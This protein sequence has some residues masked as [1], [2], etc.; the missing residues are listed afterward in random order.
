MKRLLAAATLVMFLCLSVAG[1]Q[2]ATPQPP[3]AK[4]LCVFEGRCVGYDC[5]QE[6]VDYFI[7]QLTKVDGTFAL[8]VRSDR[9]LPLA[10]ANASLDLRRFPYL[11]SGTY[12][13][14]NPVVFLRRKSGMLAV[15]LPEAPSFPR[16]FFF[17]EP[18]DSGEPTELWFIP[19]GAALPPHTDTISPWYRFQFEEIDESQPVSKRL[20]VLADRLRERPAA[21]GVIRRYFGGMKKP[22]VMNLQKQTNAALARAG[23]PADRALVSPYS[24]DFVKA[25]T[26]IFIAEI[27]PE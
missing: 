22:S 26:R 20:Q 19:K 25:R 8:C 9:P 2:T 14:P 24:V 4:L 18:I 16:T 23:M 27:L 12:E 7:G 3:T 6:V 13:S 10:L 1:G 21:Y 5:N 15:S 17:T 11:I